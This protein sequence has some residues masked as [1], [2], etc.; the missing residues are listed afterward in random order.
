MPPKNLLSGALS[1][2]L[3]QHAEN[4]VHWREWSRAAF[5]EA[6]SQNRPVLLS[7]GYAACHWCHVMARESF[8]DPEIARLMNDLFVNI[9]VDREERPD[10]DRIYQSAHYLLARRPGGWPLTM[11]L[12]PD[13]APFF[14]GT[15]FPPAPRAGMP[16]FPEILRRVA[17]AWEKHPRALAEQNRELLQILAQLDNPP[18]SANAPDLQILAQTR[19]KFRAVMDREN[20]GFGGAPK[21]PRPAELAFCAQESLRENDTDLL[22]Q[23][24]FT[25]AKIAN[26][27]ISDHIGGGFCRYAVDETWTIPH[28]EKMLY[29]NALL[30]PLLADFHNWRENNIH[31]DIPH[32]EPNTENTLLRA[33]KTAGDWVLR[34]MRD[35]GGGGFWSSLDADSEGGEG[36]FYVWSDA[37]IRE[38]LNADEYAVAA[39]RFG[40]GTGPNFEGAWHL[41]RRQPLEATAEI[42]GI[43]FSACEARWEAARAKLLMARAGRVR[44]GTDDKVLAGWNGLMI[45]GLARAGRLL[46]VSEW[47]A[48]ARGALDFARRE[49]RTAEGDLAGVWRGGRVGRR[50]FLDDYA[51]MLEGALEVLA[52]DFS[53]EV[54]DFARELGE[55]ILRDFADAD[56]GFYLTPHG[57]EEGDEGDG[58]GGEGEGV[59][60]S[61]GGLLIRRA[62]PLEDDAV[63]SANGI[64]ARG[65]LRLSW[66]LGEG[67]FG[68]A[69]GDC[70]RRLWGAARE[71]PEACPTYL[72]AAREW[73]SPPPL[74]LLVG[75]AGECREWRRVLE[76]EFPLA[77]FFI[78]PESDSTSASDLPETLRKP[79]PESGA[80]GYVCSGFSCRPPRD[81]LAELREI[82]AE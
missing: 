5:A 29:D 44:P 80:R 73:L 4:P 71:R 28:F 78:L 41:A 16:A 25:L 51:F 68:D 20:G 58:A 48:A 67:D 12:A 19:Q 3:L 52:G 33:A 81:S 60:G 43:S 54:L 69:A 45:R 49:M 23:V 39:A 72:L 64:A 37:E 15:Y 82:L 1:P 35:A 31:S 13:G 22:A 30:L 46:G 14:G 40:L 47:T 65:L 36:R 6:K 56:G 74:V 63:P 8:A 79:L 34:E 27:G 66:L 26:G 70:L 32:P 24:Q 62:M 75:D 18:H 50:G 10:L 61:G 11:F 77:L 9:K 2:Y 7:I 57:W 21:F 76:G 55:G 17:D 59:G 53:G 42:L 38:V